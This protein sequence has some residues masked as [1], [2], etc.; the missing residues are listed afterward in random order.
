MTLDTKKSKLIVIAGSLLLGCLLF[1]NAFSQVASVVIE[2][3]KEGGYCLYIKGKPVFL[4][5]L[6]YNPTPIGKGYDYDFLADSKKPWLADGKLMKKLGVNCVRI[7]SVG[8]DI[9]KTKEFIRDMYEKFGIYTI[10]SDWMGLWTYPGPNYA[11]STF[12]QKTKE[13]I[14]KIVEALKN[15]K[16]LLMWVLGNEN[17]YTFAGKICFWTSPEIEQIKEP[18]NQIARRAEIYYTFADELAAEIKKIDPVHPIALGNGEA[19]F[20]DIA[21][22]ICKNI[23]VL[24]IIAYRGK[25]FGNLF[26]HV[27]NVF[28]KPIFLSEFGADSYDSYKNK[29]DQETQAEY[30]LSQ[31]Q[32]IYANTVSSGNKEGNCIGGALFEWNDEWWKHNEG[33]TSEW[34]LHNSE[35]G[36]SNGAY[37]HDIRVS[38]GLNMNEEWFG[39]VSLKMKLEDTLDER[40][41][42]KAFSVLKD[43]FTHPSI[44]PKKPKTTSSR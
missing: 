43:F 32:D 9:E 15:E 42:K 16:G 28:D 21:A 41:P 33:Y 27:K 23:D 24:A 40:I 39:I 13:R 12:Q 2:A 19:N 1:F 31:W 25:T 17:N 35:A 44:K 38:T 4:K 30:V 3:T 8:N 34:V 7:Y 22:R 29:E 20:L 6:I 5:G 11:D 10:V 18:C 14:L 37:Y 36:W 26:R